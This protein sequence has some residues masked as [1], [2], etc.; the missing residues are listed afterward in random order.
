MKRLEL[1]PRLAR[2][3]MLSSSDV[4]LPFLL[5]TERFPRNQVS[6]AFVGEL[7]ADGLASL[8]TDRGRVSVALTDKAYEWIKKRNVPFSPRHLPPSPNN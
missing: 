4:A 6:P 1:I 3:E 2:G 8:I 7:I 5:G